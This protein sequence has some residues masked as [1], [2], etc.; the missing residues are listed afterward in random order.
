MQQFTQHTHIRANNYPSPKMTNTWMMLESNTR[1]WQSNGIGSHPNIAV[2]I[3][4]HSTTNSQANAKCH[5]FFLLRRGTIRWWVYHQRPIWRWLPLPQIIAAD[6]I[7]TDHCRDNRKYRRPQCHHCFARQ[8]NAFRQFFR[9]YRIWPKETI[10][11]WNIASL[12]TVWPHQPPLA[13]SLAVIDPKPKLL[14]LTPEWDKVCSRLSVHFQ[15]FFSA[16]SAY[17]ND[18]R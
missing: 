15:P 6:F 16:L 10:L 2:H 1:N 17:F 3:P 8:K 13:I 5:F 9:V 18:I 11:P 12:A 14:I 4:L 7:A